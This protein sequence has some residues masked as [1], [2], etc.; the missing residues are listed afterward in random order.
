MVVSGP[1]KPA[2]A[3]RY[4][5]RLLTVEKVCGESLVVGEEGLVVAVV[6]T[7]VEPGDHLG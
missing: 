1:E 5:V 2:L 4:M 6:E 3:V 7:E